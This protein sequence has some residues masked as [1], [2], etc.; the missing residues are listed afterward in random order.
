MKK[1][2]LCILLGTLGIAVYAQQYNPPLTDW[3]ID[4]TQYKGAV[5]EKKQW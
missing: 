1:N 2:L 5:V 3:M 4:G